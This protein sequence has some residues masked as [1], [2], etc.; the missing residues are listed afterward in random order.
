M[1]N[2]FN[3]FKRRKPFNLEKALAGEPVVTRDGREVEGIEKSDFPVQPIKACINGQ[4]EF[5]YRDGEYSIYNK[6]PLDL[7]MK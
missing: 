4:I 2:L 3:L 1:I 5:W 6:H 7:F